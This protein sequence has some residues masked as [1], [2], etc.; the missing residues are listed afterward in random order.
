MAGT[1]DFSV[2]RDG[3]QL[4]IIDSNFGTVTINGIT[5]FEAK[6]AVV[7]L[8]SVQIRGR[9]LHKT[10]PDGHALSFE[11]DRQDPSYEQ[12]FADAE[13]SY[14]AGLP[15]AAIFLTH[16]IN[17]PDGTV[18]QYQYLDMALA[19]DDDGS[20]EGQAKVTQKFSAE[21]GRKIRLA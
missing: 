21:A 3:A 9:I 1:N 6:P 20:F 14:F 12:Y 19:P 5:K 11:L 15:A 10:V 2:G 17:N 7:K 8:K 16:T 13:A 4:T 18:S